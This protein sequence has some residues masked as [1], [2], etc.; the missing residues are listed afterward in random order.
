MKKMLLSLLSSCLFFTLF[1]QSVYYDFQDGLVVFQLKE[2]VKVINTINDKSRVVDYKNESL[3][4]FIS[5]F[6]IVEVLRLHPDIKDQKLNRT[7]QIQLQ[8]IYQV[9]DLIKKLKRH[10]SVEYA[11][12]KELH[13][14]FLTPNDLGPI[15]SN[16]AGTSPSNNQWS[17]HK[18]QAQQA[19]DIGTGSTNI[20]VAVTDDAFRMDH[21]DLINKFT[22]PYDAVT[23]GNN[24]APCGTNAGNH[25]TH[26]AGT[27]GAQT[28]NGI[29][30]SSI[31][32]NVSVMP[33][34]IGNCNNQLTHG[35]EGIIY[36]ADNEADVVNMSWGG[37]GFSTYGQNVCTYAWN[38]G[39]I[40]VAAAGNNNE[41]TVFYPAGYNNV[42]AVASTTPTDARSSFSQYGTW[43][44]IAAPGSNIRSTYAT[45]SSAYNSIS[46]TSMASPH[47]AGLLGLMR[48]TAPSATNTA[49]I[50]CLYS[51]ADN[52]NSA[53]PSFIGQLGAGRINA[54]NSMICAA[55]FAA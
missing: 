36:A 20:I 25:G 35:Y 51:G 24:P 10:P 43:I 52:I 41:S 39:T 44:D 33:I 26:V 11:E 55:Q 46:G 21:V 30:V 31:G 2:N 19:W 50:N 23:Q 53:N 37:G 5:E 1:A 8:N 16:T 32:Y 45:S 17:L 42:I 54:Y 12:L 48:S 34:K 18:I 7:Y 28:N 6:Q 47:V 29:G 9:D 13:R 15:N 4:R 38:A 14:T 40:L 3:F 22:N 27:V 49:L